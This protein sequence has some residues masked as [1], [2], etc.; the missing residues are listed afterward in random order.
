MRRFFLP[1][2]VMPLLVAAGCGEPAASPKAGSTVHSGSP[3]TTA[4]D[5]ADK[6]EGP[7]GQPPIDGPL[8]DRRSGAVELAGDGGCTL[9]YSVEAVRERGLAFDGTVI[10]IADAGVT[11]DVGEWFA[12]GDA[13]T[14][15]LKMAGPTQTGMSESPPSYSVG[16]R[17]LVSG[18]HPIVWGCG[19]TRYFDEETAAA[20]RS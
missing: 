1:A 14:V 15:T 17:L 10:E 20:W 16:T 12:G 6:P 8:E 5:V 4:G 7:D 11:F 2:L 19:F 3:T 9:R 13:A 18:E